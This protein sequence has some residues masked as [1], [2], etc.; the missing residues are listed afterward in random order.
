[1]VITEAKAVIGTILVLTGGLLF[2]WSREVPI[3]NLD[4]RGTDVIAFGDSLIAGVGAEA[5]RTL[6]D[7]LGRKLGVPIVNAG[8]AGETTRGGLARI[9]TT[10]DALHPRIVILSLGGNDFLK[11]I[12][13]QETR[14]NLGHIIETIQSRGAMVVLLGVR[15]GIIGG[16]FDDEFEALSEQYG[17]I[18]VADVLSGIFGDTRYMSD[19]IHPNSSGYGVIAGRIDESL[20][21]HVKSFEAVASSERRER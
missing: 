17:T 14:Q 15:S 20:R 9:G 5:G 6:P 19:L 10:L 16:G 3:V 18:Y 1:M 4:S 12:P 21:E 2:L 8:I 11:K 7:Q 13:R